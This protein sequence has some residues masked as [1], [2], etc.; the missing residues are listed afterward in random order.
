MS[1]L[2]RK[3]VCLFLFSSSLAMASE[4]NFQF[5]AQ[6]NSQE[7]FVEKC[8][9][10]LLAL[11]QNDREQLLGFFDPQVVEQHSQALEALLDDMVSRQQRI[12]STAGLVSRQ[13]ALSKPGVTAEHIA[14]VNV[15][16]TFENGHIGISCGFERKDSGN[17]QLIP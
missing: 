9:V 10:W 1:G 3:I 6:D 7:I 5:H 11:E 2:Y 17:W 15:D 13:V 8:K 12:T 14:N 16:Y 4:P